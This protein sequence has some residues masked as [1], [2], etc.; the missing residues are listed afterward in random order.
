MEGDGKAEV[1]MPQSLLEKS[2]HVFGG[3]QPVLEED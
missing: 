1:S 3:I 2:S